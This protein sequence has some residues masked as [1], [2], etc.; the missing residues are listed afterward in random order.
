MGQMLTDFGGKRE[1]IICLEMG[2]NNKMV[3][4]GS[5]FARHLLIE[6]PHPLTPPKVGVF[7]P[8]W[9]GSNDKRRRFFSEANRRPII[10]ARSYPK[11]VAILPYI[12]SW[13]V[14]AGHGVLLSNNS[15]YKRG[16]QPPP[17][18]SQQSNIR[19]STPLHVRGKNTE[20][21]TKADHDGLLRIVS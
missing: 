3:M 16:E 2:R 15:C 17:P 1:K 4:G 13:Q 20:E 18:L 14:M 9:Q 7:S 19:P 11:F 10:L 6:S 12:K 21:E 5:P 8:A